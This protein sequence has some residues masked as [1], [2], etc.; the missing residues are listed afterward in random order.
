MTDHPVE[1][2]HAEVALLATELK[3]RAK[4]DLDDAA[5][6]SGQSYEAAVSGSGGTSATEALAVD[7][8]LARA[9][10]AQQA[11][12]GLQAAAKGMRNVLK[13][14]APPEVGGQCPTV[15]RDESGETVSCTGEAQ[16][17]RGLCVDCDADWRSRRPDVDIPAHIIADRNA[18]RTV[19]CQCHAEHDHAPGVCVRDLE[20][21]QTVGRCRQCREAENPKCDDCGEKPPAPRRTI[22]EGCKTRRRRKTFAWHDPR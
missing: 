7:G 20:P 13:H 18:R 8:T 10:D 17:H 15:S 22:C 1:Q 21:G 19:K 16:T 3:L 9:H 6:P 2:A 5:Q 4:V 12:R 14:M 11:L